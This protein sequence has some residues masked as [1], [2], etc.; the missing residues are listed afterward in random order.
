MK[1]IYII[2]KQFYFSNYSYRKKM[3]NEVCW[4]KN[5]FC[6]RDNNLPAYIG[7]YKK[8]WWVNGEP[9]N[10]VIGKITSSE[11]LFHRI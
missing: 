1:I 5:G 3:K 11:R 10:F 8:E 6:H 7:L 4:G 9:K 2:N